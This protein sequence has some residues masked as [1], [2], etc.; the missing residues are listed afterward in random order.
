MF[1][2]GNTELEILEIATLNSEEEKIEKFKEWNDFYELDI[3]SSVDEEAT[4]PCPILVGK[5]KNKILILNWKKIST[6]GRHR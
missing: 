5:L 2:S 1:G 6:V 4:F 3:E